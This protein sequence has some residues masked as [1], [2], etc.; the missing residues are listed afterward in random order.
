[1][2]KKLMTRTE[3][4][5]HKRQVRAALRA[6]RK[7][8]KP[9]V[10]EWTKLDDAVTD[11]ESVEEQDELLALQSL[12]DTVFDEIEEFGKKEAKKI[13]ALLKRRPWD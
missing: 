11:A 2:A 5:A 9:L 6:L 8:T 10:K 4:A 1:M 7:A 13:R 12:I 3:I